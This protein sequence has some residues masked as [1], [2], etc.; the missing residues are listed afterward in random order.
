MEKGFFAY[1]TFVVAY[2]ALL[3]LYFY[4][5]FVHSILPFATNF[6]A[7][8][9]WTT[10][11]LELYGALNVLLLGF[12]RFRKPWAEA[13]PQPPALPGEGDEEQSLPP[14][15]PFDVAILVPCYS[16]PDDVIFGTI[17]AALALRDPLASRV[18]VVLCDD[19]GRPARKQRVQQLGT[20]LVLYVSRPKIPNVPRHGKAGNLNYALREVLYP[21]GAPPP[22][23]AV[24]VVFD[25]D[26]EAHG[27]FLTHTLPYLACDGTVALVQ[28]PQ[29]FYNVVPSADIFNHHNLTFY[30]AMQP[31]LDAWGA[32]VCCGTNFVARATA[33]HHVDW[34]PTESITEDYL[35]S[36]KLAT[37]GWRVRFHAAVV[38]TGEAPEDL[39]QVFKQRNRWCC[40]CFQVFLHPK[41]PVWIIGLFRRSPIKAVCWLNA[42][43]SYFGT[44]LTVPLW[45]IVPALS[46]Y[47]EVHPVRALSP[48]FVLLWLVYFT[49]LVL[50]VE[51]MPARLNRRAAAFLGSKCNAIFWYCFASALG[52]AIIGRIDASR[53]KEFEVTEKRG[54]SADAEL[55]R[56]LPSPD[57]LLND[58]ASRALSAQ[59]AAAL[60][61]GARTSRSSR[62]EEVAAPLIEASSSLQPVPLPAHSTEGQAFGGTKRSSSSSSGGGSSGS[63]LAPMGDETLHTAT[64]A[65]IATLGGRG[66]SNGGGGGAAACTCRDGILDASGDGASVGGGV[67]VPMSNGLVG[68]GAGVTVPISAA[69]SEGTRDSDHADVV[70]HQLVLSAELLFLVAGLLHRAFGPMARAGVFA[71]DKGKGKWHDFH[72]WQQLGLVLVPAAWLLLNTVPHG[73][74][75]AYAY[76]PH[77]HRVQSAAV[78]YALRAQSLLLFFV[79][80]AMVQSAAMHWL[81]HHHGLLHHDHAGNDVDSI[82]MG[83]YGDAYP[84]SDEGEVDFAYDASD[85]D[86]M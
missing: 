1:R 78:K 43:F 72:T 59:L 26:M 16:E 46:L 77:A 80:L 71:S 57:I 84:Y 48:G 49:L 42:P 36:L 63:V 24:V 76:L 60:T 19:G 10:C 25:C 68:R 65:K 22:P 17:A 9:Q 28:T 6:T 69:P 54:F 15:G 56:A 37:A 33:L 86:R 29:H 3:P 82:P 70:F 55:R 39:K 74:A 73:M 7:I 34:F 61:S 83:A 31:G 66:L 52:S 21:G 79:S 2:A 12:I 20:D 47:A 85:P 4:F 40:G 44:L 67:G 27:D 53:A 35:L 45:A 51:M 11:M 30:Q 18:R 8:Y 41:L 75:L 5:R 81:A 13:A 32:T 38:A 14:H 64:A 50:V 62:E 23:S 58:G